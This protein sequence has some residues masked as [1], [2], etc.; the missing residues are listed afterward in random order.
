[1]SLKEQHQRPL[2]RKWPLILAAFSLCLAAFLGVSALVNNAAGADRP[3]GVAGI[4]GTPAY[5]PLMR[6]DPTP[7]PTATPTAVPSPTPVANPEFVKNVPLPDAQCPNDVAFNTLSRYIYIAN[8]FSSNVSVLQDTE[9]ILNIPTGFWPTH[10]AAD[11]HSTLTYVTVMHDRVTALSGAGIVGAIPDHYE[12]YGVA[13][14]PVNGYTYITDL[15]SLVQVADGYSLLTN[16]PLTDPDTGGGAGWLQPV[17]VDPTTGLVYV[18]SW[19]HGRLYV[20]DGTEVIASYRA[21][22]GMKDMAIDPVRGYIYMAHESPNEEYPHNIS[23]FNIQT[24]TVTPRGTAIRSRAVAV[25]PLSGYAYFTNEE[26][27]SVT[28]MSG[29]QVLTNL[30]AGEWPWNVGVN[31]NTGHV[32][33]TNRDSHNITV[34]KDGAL[35]NTIPAQGIRPYAVGVDTTTNDVYIANRGLEFENPPLF[36]PLCTD[37]S[38]TISR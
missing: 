7:T 26:N 18:A 15:D 14:N 37:A 2:L 5:L 13:V 1:M 24:Q 6:K 28:V 16:V 29:E 17:V 10:L 25:D 27:N 19:S 31:P 21:G 22:W 12:P 35:I 23:V 38:V 8:N 11:P 34:Y 4:E 36:T 3:P 33:V 20:L 32:F 30:P 9:F